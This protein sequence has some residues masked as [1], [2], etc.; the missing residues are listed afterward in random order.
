MGTNTLWLYYKYILQLH[1]MLNLYN[2]VL[3]THYQ[4]LLQC[5][6][7]GG[8]SPVL[9]KYSP[10]F[11]Q[12]FP[13]FPVEALIFIKLPEVYRQAYVYSWVNTVALLSVHLVHVNFTDST[14]V[15]LYFVT[16]AT[17]VAHHRQTTISPTF[18]KFSDSSLNNVKFSD[19]SK[20]S[21]QVATGIKTHN[22]IWR[23]MKSFSWI[24]FV[25]KA[26][27]NG[28]SFQL[29]WEALRHSQAVQWT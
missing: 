19:F 17:V 14:Q 22:D 11:H 21:R 23:M 26:D 20:F 12:F 7:Q 27:D 6:E 4:R 8:H 10:T 18:S 2:T 28:Q 5:S 25:V 24:W 9:V 3:P 16:I 29:E 13:V 15:M 1:K